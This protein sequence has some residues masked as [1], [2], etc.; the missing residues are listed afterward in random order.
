[1]YSFLS[2]F[3]AVCFINHTG[4]C[5]CSLNAHDSSLEDQCRLLI[6]MKEAAVALILDA[7]NEDIAQVCSE[8]WRTHRRVLKK[9]VVQ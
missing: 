9:K 2:S 7:E 3:T 6:R 4:L 5:N 1:M 8:G